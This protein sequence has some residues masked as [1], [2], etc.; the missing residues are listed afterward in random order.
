M[1]KKLYFYNMGVTFDNTN[2]EDLE[3]CWNNNLYACKSDILNGLWCEEYGYDFN[4]ENAIK[5]AEDYVKDGNNTT[6]G[7]VKEVTISDF[8]KETWNNIYDELIKDYGFKDRKEASK[9]G[10]VPADYDYIEDDYSPNYAEPDISFYKND[11]GEIEKNTIHVL[12]ENEIN[13]DTVNFVRNLYDE[14]PLKD[15]KEMTEIQ[16]KEVDL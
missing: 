15:T 3:E 14:E 1:K 5:R 8:D 2:K 12:H 6:Y 13:K 11:K 9:Y 16:D 7:Y 4:K 10:Y